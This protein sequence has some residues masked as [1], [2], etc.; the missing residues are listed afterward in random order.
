MCRGRVIFLKTGVGEEKGRSFWFF[1]GR[2]GLG[3]GGGGGGGGSEA[4][5]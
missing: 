1:V 4:K 3:E 5:F 2:K